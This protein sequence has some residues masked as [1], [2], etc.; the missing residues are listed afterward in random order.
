MLSSVV[1]GAVTP[2]TGAAAAA[3]TN[4]TSSA[5]ASTE[6]SGTATTAATP[7]A[8]ATAAGGLFSMQVSLQSSG[9]LTNQLAF[10]NAVRTIGPRRALIVSTQVAPGPEA[11][12]VPSITTSSLLTTQLTIF[13]APQTPAQLVELKR[14]L[15]GKIGS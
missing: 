2:V 10:L 8:P 15:S 14:L 6:A 13:S 1:I 9:T 5:P 12:K 4:G 3:P 11:K 7:A